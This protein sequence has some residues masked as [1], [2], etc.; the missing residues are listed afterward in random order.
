LFLVFAIALWEKG[1]P[2]QTLQ[3]FNAS[4]A[5]GPCYAICKLHPIVLA[6]SK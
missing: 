5:N 3:T 2:Q 6:K 4:Q 1:V